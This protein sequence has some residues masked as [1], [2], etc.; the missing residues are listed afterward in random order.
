MLNIT[1]TWLLSAAL[2]FFTSRIIDGFSIPDFTMAFI[3]SLFIGLVNIA[4][5]PL[6]KSL[7][8]KM[9]LISLGL[10][11]FSLNAVVLKLA[12]ELMKSFELS[13][14]GPALLAA[15]F[16]AVIQ[17]LTFLLGTRKTDYQAFG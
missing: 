6:M 15:F 14:W 11:T 16:L 8:F 7:D 3:A 4:I 10:F 9:N 5:R 12:A 2:L 13:G 1:L 17:D